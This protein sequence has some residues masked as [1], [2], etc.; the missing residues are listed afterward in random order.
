MTASGGV[1]AIVVSRDLRAMLDHCL[2]HLD[3]ALAAIGG[4]SHRV[5]VVDNASAN[6]YGATWPAGSPHELIRVDR[7]A[8]FSAANNLAARRAPNDYYLLL[9]NDVFLARQAIREMVDAIEEPPRA[10]ICGARLVFPSGAIQHCGVAFGAGSTGPYH[11]KRGAP[12]EIVPR[13]TR[14]WQAV[15]GACMLIRSDVWNEAGGL[16][17]SYPFGLEDIDLCLRARQ[18]GWR[19]VCAN[20]TESLH[21]ESQTPDRARLDRPSRRLF[22]RRWG[23]RYTVDHP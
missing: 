21:F 6:P 15:T 17:E 4:G 9:N 19:T 23:G 10:G 22:M 14:E 1:T 8:S 16:D 20:G 11:W 7:H 12:P 13:T 5:V 18:R 2:A 3:D